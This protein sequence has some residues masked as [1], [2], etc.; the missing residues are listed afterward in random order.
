[1]RN[2]L[3]R[4]LLSVRLRWRW[5][6]R[7]LGRTL[8]RVARRR[9]GRSSLVFHVRLHLRVA[10]V[11]RV[12]RVL[13]MLGVLGMLWVLGVLRMLRRRVRIL[14]L[15]RLRLHGMLHIGRHALALRLVDAWLRHVGVTV[16]LWWPGWPDGLHAWVPPKVIPG[17][18]P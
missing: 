7:V 18:R 6:L 5:A 13:R 3:R 11:L 17:R 15:L 8:R 4:K 16:G 2:G 9:N 12:L 10:R 1:M 14:L